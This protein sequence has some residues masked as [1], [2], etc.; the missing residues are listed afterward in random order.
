MSKQQGTFDLS[1]LRDSIAIV[2]GAGNNGIGWGLCKHAAEHLGM[3]VVAM[4]LHQSLVDNAQ[5]RLQAA[6]PEVT[7]LGLACDVTN[8]ESLAASLETI[9]AAIPGKRI[10]AVF[11]NAGTLFHR[12]ILKSTPEQWATTMNVNVL[13][14]VNTIQAYV[15]DML[16]DQAGSLFCATASIGGL[17]RGDGGTASYQASKHA[18]VSITESLSF[19]LA[20]RAPQL[21]VHVLCPCIVESALPSTSATN[22]EA[23]NLSVATAIEP[24][25]PASNGF[26]MTTERHAQQVFDQITVGNHYLLTDN[27]RPYVDHDQPFG[28]LNLVQER[29]DNIQQLTLDNSDAWRPGPYG[30]ATSILKGPMFAKLRAKQEAQLKKEINEGG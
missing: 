12:S 11:A 23:A 15:P 30:G 1:E 4:D 9:K 18:V 26:S 25:T 19:E 16:T 14:V 24:G 27:V 21:R 28:G 2:T 29:A 17:V 20:K 10:G 22:L 13:G 7:C 8:P 5:Q 3:H 6:Y